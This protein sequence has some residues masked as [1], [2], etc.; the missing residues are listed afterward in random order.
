VA[1]E[2]GIFLDIPSARRSARILMAVAADVATDEFGE[3][4][5]ADVLVA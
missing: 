5:F 4:I 2:L 3:R 1:L